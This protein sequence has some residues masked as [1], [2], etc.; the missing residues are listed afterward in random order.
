LRQ[1]RVRRCSSPDQDDVV[2]GVK[3]GVRRAISVV[4]IV[5][6]P[7]RRIVEGRRSRAYIVCMDP[8]A[9]VPAHLSN[10]DLLAEL[11]RLAASER[12]ATAALVGLLAEAD[13]RRL[14][15]A[16]GCSSLFTYCTE[17]LHLSE[18][19]AYH[20]IRAARAV[21]TFP[22][23]LAFL[24][25]G[26]VTLTA[27]TL[28][29]PHLTDENCERLLAEA[30]H[31]S[32]RDVESLV[33]SIAPMPDVRASVR[34]LPTTAPNPATAAS[35]GPRAVPA[36]AAGIAADDALAIQPAAPLGE[37]AQASDESAP[38]AP[39]PARRPSTVCV[40]S[41]DRYSL[42]VTL[43]AEGHARLR[44][45]QDLLRHTVPSSDP[46][47][48]VERALALLVEQLERTKFAAKR[49][50][51]N[52]PAATATSP[53]HDAGS[54]AVRPPAQKRKTA[55]RTIPAAVKRAVWARDEGRCT[56]TGAGVRCQETGG[57]E[58]HHGIPVAD[59]GQA[60]LEN[61]RL[62][63]RSHHAYESERW[64]GEPSGR[65][66]RQPASTAAAT[67]RAPS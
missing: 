16:E 21:R 33:R 32:T 58:F 37:T 26:S 63:C 30:R 57:L 44:R 13:A 14:H 23:I 62:L 42:R 29:A 64:F 54:A 20:R 3:I 34:R 61:V 38:C 65:A 45:A 10:A 2:T 47:A 27:V 59:G 6:R 7:A 52:P 31:R 50:N 9:L 66:D 60:S 55:A 12:A 53:M 46:A 48:I 51:A 24:R 41:P 28:L 4:V 67:R 18:Q 8:L 43:S 40:L 49:K 19:A 39:P 36:D 22:A 11:A 35:R 56:F 5:D 15:I 1:V 25:D 17:R